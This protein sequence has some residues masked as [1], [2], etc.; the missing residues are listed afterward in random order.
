MAWG[1]VKDS[2]A[3]YLRKRA[4]NRNERVHGVREQ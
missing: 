2:G 3:G 1:A 4:R